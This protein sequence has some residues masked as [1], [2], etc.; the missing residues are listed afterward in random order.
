MQS[1][2]SRR[3]SIIGSSVH[4]AIKVWLVGCKLGNGGRKAF[5]FQVHA[6]ELS[7]N[8]SKMM[9]RDRVSLKICLRS[10][11]KRKQRRMLKWSQFFFLIPQWINFTFFLGQSFILLLSHQPIYFLQIILFI[12]QSRPKFCR[13]QMDIGLVPNCEY[14]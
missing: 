10:T 12:S 2:K 7:R 14:I 5:K 9:K 1:V 13:Y 6:S 8:K 4:V 11:R 3:Q